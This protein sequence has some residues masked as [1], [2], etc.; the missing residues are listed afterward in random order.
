MKHRCSLRFARDQRNETD[1]TERFLLEV[2]TAARDADQ[3]L[4]AGLAE[5]NQQASAFVELR[6]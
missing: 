3:R 4:P 1:R 2:V 6:E 5:R